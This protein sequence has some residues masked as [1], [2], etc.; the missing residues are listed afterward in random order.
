MTRKLRKLS[1]PQ[2]GAAVGVS[3]QQIQRYERG[4]NSLSVAMLFKLADALDVRP[5]ALL[6]PASLVGGSEPTVLTSEAAEVLE[7]FLRL[8][9]KAARKHLV[10]LMKALAATP[11]A[12]EAG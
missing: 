9:S 3:F 4:E 8:R 10:G 11:D 2:L 12:S 5:E 7:M 1:Q 6:G